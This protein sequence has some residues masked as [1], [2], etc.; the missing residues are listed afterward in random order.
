MA[1]GACF[2]ALGTGR[3]CNLGLL[4]G[5]AWQQVIA[6]EVGVCA[7]WVTGKQL[8]RLVC[9]DHG[10]G[11]VG[12]LRTGKA[13]LKKGGNLPFRGSRRGG[14]TRSGGDVKP[15]RVFLLM[16]APDALCDAVQ[17]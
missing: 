7:A 4:R 10:M 3:F 9:G 12:V 8:P 2:A 17:E 13:G 16:P 14:L 5:K 6:L 1:F 15:A 11:V